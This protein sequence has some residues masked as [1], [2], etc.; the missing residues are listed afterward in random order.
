[1]EGAILSTAR[2]FGLR[3]SQRRPQNAL[4]RLG[5]RL[6]WTRIA[7][8]HLEIAIGKYEAKDVNRL[9]DTL[10]SLL[11]ETAPTLRSYHEDIR[12]GGIFY[13][14]LGA[15]DASQYKCMTS[16]P[17]QKPWFGD[18]DTVPNEWEH[19]SPNSNPSAFASINQIRLQSWRTLIVPFYRP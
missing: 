17:M 16:L 18:R 19:A 13:R 1:M 7:P 6:T 12:D 9:H 5:N 15:M 14:L 4:V 11:Q 2:G 3:N 10:R 8:I